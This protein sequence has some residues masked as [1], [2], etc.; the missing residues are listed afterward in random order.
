MLATNQRPPAGEVWRTRGCS[1]GPGGGCGTILDHIFLRRRGR[2][3]LGEGWPSPK[4]MTI[5]RASRPT[6]GHPRRGV[7]AA[8][9]TR[10]AAG[11]VLDQPR[12]GRRAPRRDATILWASRRRPR[13]PKVTFGLPQEEFGKPIGGVPRL[14]RGC[15]RRPIKKG[16]DELPLDTAGCPTWKHS[17]FPHRSLEL[18]KEP[19]TWMAD[20]NLLKRDDIDSWN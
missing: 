2:G 9:A 14:A 8:A 19:P 4:R 3:V 1:K 7:E 18:K 6:N 11:E 12:P 15:R 10:P 17:F 20:G 13:E 16:P 5:G